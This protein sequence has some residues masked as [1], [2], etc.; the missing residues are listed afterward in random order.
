MTEKKSIDI[1]KLLKNTICLLKKFSVQTICNL[2]SENYITK[3]FQFC[4]NKSTD[5]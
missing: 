1:I 5:R 3:Q 4:P 2:N